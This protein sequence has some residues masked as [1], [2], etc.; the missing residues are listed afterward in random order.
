MFRWLTRNLSNIALSIILA[1]V[2]WVVAV[3]EANPNREDVFRTIPIVFTNQPADSI[4]YDLSAT[5]VDVWLRAPETAWG[6][7]SS[8]V[9]S[10]TVDLS[11][12]APGESLHAVKIDVPDSVARLVRVVRV[13]PASIGVK[14]EPISI[15]SV[16]VDVSV[17]GDPPVGYK[18]G[19]LT[20]QPATVTV[21]GPASWVSQV[22]KTTGEF[23]VQNARAPVSE[24]IAL[25]PV[26]A[27]GQTVPNVEMEP[28]RTRLTVAIEQLAGFRDLA[29]KIDLTGTIASGYRIV[30][31]NATPLVVTV[32]G[33]PT[34]LESLQG[35]VSTESIDINGA[36][37]NIEKDAQLN[38]PVGVALLGQQSVHV[39]V[40]IEPIVGSLTVPGRPITIGLQSGLVAQVSPEAVEVILV[41][42][43]PVLDSINLERDVRVILDL[44][45]LGIGTHQ[46]TPQVEAPEG[47]AAQSILPATVQVTIERAI[48]EGLRPRSTPTPSTAPTRR[49]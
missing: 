24:T 31:V 2:V 12:P 48:P 40:K 46:I 36:Q 8:R 5:T 1:V 29:V 3:N 41:G 22:V 47:V 38:L 16:P 7:L 35:F 43:L 39:S 13:E 23:S 4:V 32:F 9:I 19:Q 34:A 25:K 11:G 10:A 21:S 37:A 6:T 14:I 33:S 18:V 28:D 27:N 20:A 49:P 45:G 17:V 26:D 44:T 30:D 15:A 42:A